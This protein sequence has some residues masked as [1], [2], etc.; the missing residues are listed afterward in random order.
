MR[1]KS[2]SARSDLI[3]V[4]S[5]KGGVELVLPVFGVPGGI[6]PL[7]VLGCGGRIKR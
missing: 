2:F 3:D 6:E 1:F 4:N 7:P 5:I